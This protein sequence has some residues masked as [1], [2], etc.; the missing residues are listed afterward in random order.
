MRLVARA[1]GIVADERSTPPSQEPIDAA[2]LRRAPRS[3]D[4]TAQRRTRQRTRAARGGRPATIPLRVTS[5]MPTAAA[6]PPI[7]AAVRLARALRDELSRVIVGQDAVVH[8]ILIA[9]FA[10]GHV[11]LRGVPGLAKTLLIKTLA[12]AIALKF[13]RIQFTPDLMPSDIVGTEVIEE[14]RG[15]GKRTIRFIAGPL[16]ANII[17][18]DEIN[19]TPPKTQAALLEAMQEYQVTVSGVRHAL[20]RPLFVLATQ[21]PIEQEGTY[22][23]PEAQLDRFLFNVVI[24]YPTADEERRILR[25]TTSDHD[26]TVSVVTSGADIEQMR[27]LVREIPTADNVV[28]YAVRLVRATRPS[29]AW[30]RCGH[31]R[32]PPL[33]ALGGRPACRPGV[34][35]R[36]QGP[37]PPRRPGGRGPRRRA[38]RRPSGAAASRAGELPGRSRGH[39]PRRR[40]RAAAGVRSPDDGSC[41]THARWPTP[42]SWR[43]SAIST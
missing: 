16:F 19:R 42:R 2:R 10:G 4:V 12:Q 26:A 17:L 37:R 23:L 14:D 27:H 31:R 25:A 41:L 21:N 34:A 7:D 5:S 22:P 20:E 24:D 9:F 35:A 33:R 40:R 13:S 32:R 3:A 11:L 28:D 29:P 15:T 39:H 43:G 38:G 30:R 6:N 18:A 1:G 8:Q 36:R